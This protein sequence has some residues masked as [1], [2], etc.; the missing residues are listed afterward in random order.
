VRALI[1]RARALEEGFG[2]GALDE[3]LVT[4]EGLPPAMG[5]SPERA[6]RHFQRAL[7][8]SGGKRPS[9]FVTLAMAVSLPAQD[10]AEFERLLEQALAVSPD[11][12][13]SN[14][15]ATLVAHQRARTLRD[16]LDALFPPAEPE[17]SKP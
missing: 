1:D 8:L 4:L 7:E 10:R 17:G 15:L 3:A 16:R 9:V 14:R 6:R 11:A 13:P 12:D 2:E 5:G